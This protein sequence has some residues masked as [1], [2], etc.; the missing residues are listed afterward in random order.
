MKYSRFVSRAGWQAA[1]RGQV[2]RL[3]TEELTTEAS[4]FTDRKVEQLQQPLFR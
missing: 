4:F 2:W 3:Q 1:G